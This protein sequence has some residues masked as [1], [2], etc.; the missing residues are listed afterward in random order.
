MHQHMIAQ[1]IEGGV[2]GEEIF[3]TRKP[4]EERFVPA[5]EGAHQC[6][7]RYQPHRLNIP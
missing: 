4:V 6:W 7:R 1:T 3:Q 2:G 5:M